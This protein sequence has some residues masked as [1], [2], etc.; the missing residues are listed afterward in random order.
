MK[1]SL[2]ELRNIVK[3]ELE[4][5]QE[6]LDHQSVKGIVNSAS[7]LLHAIDKFH[8]S[9]PSAAMQTGVSTLLTSL[10]KSLEDMIQNPTSYVDRP[11]PTVL[12]I[13]KPKNAE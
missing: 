13:K 3:E 6:D 2:E 12:T 1:I 9:E 10:R 7:S 11:P 5:V 4:L 8:K